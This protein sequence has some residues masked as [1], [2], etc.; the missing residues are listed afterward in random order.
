MTATAG[1][2]LA[3]ACLA[4]VAAGFALAL[5][6]WRPRPG[7]GRAAS[8]AFAAGLATGGISFVLGALHWL[9]HLLT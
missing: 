6:S 7:D 2:L 8:V 1:L 5:T 3:L 4:I 9:A